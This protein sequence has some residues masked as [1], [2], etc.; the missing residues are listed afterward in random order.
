MY[1]TAVNDIHPVLT[2]RERLQNLADENAKLRGLCADF[3]KFSDS[4]CNQFD[5][6]EHCRFMGEDGVN[7]KYLELF[8]RVCELRI[9]VD[10]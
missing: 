1:G 4:M 10:E 2:R 7:C 6:C 5:D 8:Q 9:E 3:Y